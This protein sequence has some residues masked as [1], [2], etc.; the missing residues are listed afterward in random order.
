MK[1]M[2]RD[3][4]GD[5]RFYDLP[6]MPQDATALTDEQWLQRHLIFADDYNRRERAARMLDLQHRIDRHLRQVRMGE[7]V[8]EDIAPLDAEMKRLADLP[9]QPGWPLVCEWE[10]P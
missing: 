9:Q 3:P 4:S 6:H 2:Q 8:S 1:F 7:Y 5:L 10:A